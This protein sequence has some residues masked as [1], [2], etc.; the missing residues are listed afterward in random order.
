MIDRRNSFDQPVKN[1]IKIQKN[2][3]KIATG[4][5]DD[6]KASYLLDYPFKE[7][8][9]SFKVIAIPLSKHQALDSD[10]KAIQQI[11][12]TRNIVRAGKTIRKGNKFRFFTR[13][14]K[15]TLNLFSF[16]IIPL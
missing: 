5:T 3:R 9:I 12:F 7:I 11:N 6:Y 8:R 1:D 15:S 13:N 2:I 4:Q 16:D 14:R 10:P